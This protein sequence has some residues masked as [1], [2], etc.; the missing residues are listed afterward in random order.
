MYCVDNKNVKFVGNRKLQSPMLAVGAL[1]GAA[2]AA[3]WLDRKL[4]LTADV[5]RIR[6]LVKVKAECVQRNCASSSSPDTNY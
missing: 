4:G 5:A 3:K 1:V 2:V 6:K